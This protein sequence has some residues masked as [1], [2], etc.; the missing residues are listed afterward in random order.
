LGRTVEYIGE[1]NHAKKVDLYQKAIA[2]TYPIGF[3]E[4][5]GLVMVEAM[6]CG[7]PILALNRGSVPEI[8]SDGETAVIAD[9]S[10]QLIAR[11]PEVH[12]IQPQICRRRVE[13]MFSKERMI[14]AYEKVYEN[15]LKANSSKAYGKH[16]TFT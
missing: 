11:F 3:Q 9:S 15:V 10:E 1:V 12:T 8:L 6:A 7:T 4:P 13:Q 14:E 5:F 16:Y 2:V